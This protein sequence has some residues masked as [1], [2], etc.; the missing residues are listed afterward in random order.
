ML[1]NLEAVIA[2]F[3]I[4]ELVTALFTNLL[5]VTASS[6]ILEVVT[7][8]SASSVLPTASGWICKLLNTPDRS[9]PAFELVVISLLGSVSPVLVTVNSDPFCWTAIPVDPTI[10]IVSPPPDTGTLVT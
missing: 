2:L 1:S 5:V 10:E 3:A 6:V 7:E 4:F 8:P 9:P